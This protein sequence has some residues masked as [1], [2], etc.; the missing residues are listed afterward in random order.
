MNRITQLSIFENNQLGDFEKLNDVLN[1][2]PD[3]KLI[4]LLEEERGKGRNDYPVFTMWRAFLARS[5]GAFSA[6]FVFQ[7]PTVAIPLIRELKRNSQLREVC[8]FQTRIIRTKKGSYRYQLAP[9]EAA[10]SPFRKETVRSTKVCWMLC[11]TS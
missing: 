6:A 4:A 2:L 7:H 1:A 9:T 5:L 10:F 8:G 11:S 3:E